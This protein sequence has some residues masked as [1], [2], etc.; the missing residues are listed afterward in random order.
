MVQ[1][2]CHA[3]NERTLACR[4]VTRYGHVHKSQWVATLVVRTWTVS[5]AVPYRFAVQV[6]HPIHHFVRPF[7]A[8]WPIQH[9]HNSTQ[10]EPNPNENFTPSAGNH[11]WKRNAR[12]KLV[13]TRFLPPLVTALQVGCITFWAFDLGCIL[14]FMLSSEIYETRH[15]S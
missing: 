7:T 3:S 4:Q 15:T 1:N 13:E 12:R 14:P 9:C 10:A 8:C 2:W 5:E 11:T 6:G